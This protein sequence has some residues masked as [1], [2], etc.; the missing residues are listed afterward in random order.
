M[1]ARETWSKLLDATFAGG[2]RLL[3]IGEKRLAP[4]AA[5]QARDLGYL[6]ECTEPFDGI[7]WI[8]R[9]D[10][11]AGLGTLRPWLRANGA[12]LLV[13]DQSLLLGAVT[14]AFRLS[15]KPD[16]M[17]AMQVCEALLMAG[18]ERPRVL[19]E[20]QPRLVLAANKPRRLGA[21]DAF[22]EQPA[23]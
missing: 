2:E 16:V 18:F 11:R 9:G 1:S 6:R 17:A 4:R 20:A 3:W 23:S 15:S 13:L 8:M 5:Q 7:G 12:L 21:L 10:V 22:F 19:V 14:R